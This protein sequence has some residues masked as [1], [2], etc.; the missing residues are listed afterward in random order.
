MSSQPQESYSPTLSAGSDPWFF[1]RPTSAPVYRTPTRSR[2]LQDRKHACRECDEVFT[3]GYRLEEHAKKYNHRCY[4]CTVPGCGKSYCRRDVLLRHTLKHKTSKLP[5]KVCQKSFKR[6]DHLFQHLRSQH[7]DSDGARDS[8]ALYSVTHS[9][10]A[11]IDN[12]DIYPDLENN[13]MVSSPNFQSMSQGK[14]N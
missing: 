11:L 4:V 1:N 10:P 5:C 2:P 14:S 12:R 8:S 6:K 9:K 7:P 13:A 3:T